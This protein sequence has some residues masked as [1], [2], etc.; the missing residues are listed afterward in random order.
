M[1]ESLMRR[2]RSISRLEGLRSLISSALTRISSSC[3]Y[4]ADDFFGL[5]FD[6][7]R[8]PL[9]TAVDMDHHQFPSSELG[10]NPNSHPSAFACFG[11][12]IA[13]LDTAEWVFKDLYGRVEK[14]SVLSKVQLV[15]PFI[16]LEYHGCIYIL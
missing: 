11:I 16:P 6:F 1:S 7:E 8:F 14:Y 5:F 15:F 2:N 4:D 12:V 10:H 9:V 13:G 3:G